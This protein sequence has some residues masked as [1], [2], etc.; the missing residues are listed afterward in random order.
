[1]SLC[2]KLFLADKY[3]SPPVGLYGLWYYPG[4]N[5]FADE[6][7]NILHDFSHLFNTWVLDEWKK[8]RD[9]ATLIDKNGDMCEVYYQSSSDELDFIN[10]INLNKSRERMIY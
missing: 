8:T 3:E 9:Y 10:R 7:D 4:I 5:R 2:N 6:D 1:M